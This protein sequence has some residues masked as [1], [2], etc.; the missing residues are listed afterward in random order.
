MADGIHTFSDL[1]TDFM[2]RVYAL[3]HGKSADAE[4]PYGHARIETAVT[5]ILG[6]ILFA[7]GAGI[8]INAGIRLSTA[9][10]F[11]DPPQP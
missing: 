9:Q 8:A 7:V 4:H 6:I 5:M 3:K 2:V 10:V 1:A 11:V